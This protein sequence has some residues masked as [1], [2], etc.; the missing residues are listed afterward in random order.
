MA[1]DPTNSDGLTQQQVNPQFNP[2]APTQPDPTA[3]P[4]STKEI[5]WW[6][7]GKFGQAGYALWNSGGKNAT[8][9][10]VIW[11]FVNSVGSNLFELMHRPDV[12]QARPPQKQFLYDAYQ[13]LI[14]SQKR[15]NDRAITFTGPD[16]TRLDSQHSG[17]ALQQFLAY[18]VPFF[19]GRVQQ[20]DVLEWAGLLLQMLS[21]AAQHEDNKYSSDIT[22]LFTDVMNA[23]FDR[24]LKLLATRYFGYTATSYAAAKV[25]PPDANGKPTVIPFQLKQSDWTNYDPTGSFLTTEFTSSLPQIQ[26]EPVENDLAAIRGLAYGTAIQKAERW[27]EDAAAMYGMGGAAYYTPG[28]GA[29]YGAASGQQ[30]Q[31]GAAPAIGTQANAANAVPPPIGRAPQ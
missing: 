25:G 26:W 22:Q 31:P 23:R 17:P 18:P 27:T 28:N 2:N 12:Y 29:L 4:F 15:M 21:E 5:L 20:P 16:Q 7:N 24:I 30:A 1:A 10:S 11:G 19:G 3:A 13:L 6:N 8:G 9:N 14:L